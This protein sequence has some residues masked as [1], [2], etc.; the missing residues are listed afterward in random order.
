MSRTES[1]L[2][3]AWRIWIRLLLL[4]FPETFRHEVG[5]DL[6]ADCTA[7]PPSRIA[8]FVRRSASAARELVPAGLGARLD[9]RRARRDGPRG[10]LGGGLA[11]D[12]RYGLRLLIRQPVYSGAV[13]LTLAL[14][15]GLA[16]AVFGIVDATL[17]RPLPFPADRRLLSIGSRW[18]GV[19]HTAV[20]IP[21]YLD[22]RAQA[23]SLESIAAYRHVSASLVGDDGPERLGG[24]AVT[25]SFFDV[26]GVQPALGRVFTDAE[27]GP[28][29]DRVAVLAHHT[30][31]QRFGRD[32]AALGRA[33]R[34]D[35]QPVTIIGVM[36]ASFRLPA[37]DTEIWF[38][39]RVNPSDPGGRGAH[40][41]EVIARM[42]AGVEP[43]A[44]R[45]ELAAIGRQFA[46]DYPQN[47]PEGSG[48]GV[49]V[50]TLRDH[51]VGD[52]SGPLR[53]LFGA[54]LFV[55]L[56]AA[57]NTSGLMLARASE[58][59]AEFAARAALGASRLRLVRQVVVEGA[60]AGAAGGA[61][62][63]LGAE[64][65]LRA[66]EPG[67]PPAVARPSTLALD[68][69]VIAFA[70]GVTGCAAAL[71]GAFAASQAS[72]ASAGDALRSGA[73]TTAGR[74]TR[75]VRAALVVGE[76][77]LAFLLLTGA[78][79]SIRGF[80]RLLD[81]DPGLD[82]SSV[83]TARL[84]LPAARYP[85]IRD[86]VAFFHRLLDSLAASP[87]VTHAGAVSILP[88]S[89][90]DTDA[91]FGVEGYV[92]PV[93]GQ[94]P[95]S[96]ARYVTG[97]YFRALDI[98]LV[99]GRLFTRADG[100]DAPFVAI[101]SD[102]LARKYWPGVD[103]VGRRMKMWSLDDDGPWRTV[104][105][106]VGDVRHFG[107]AEDAP[108][109]LYLPVAQFPQRTLT[110]VVEAAEGLPAGRL[111]EER[112]RALDPAQPV[113][114][115][116]TMDGWVER[117]TAQPRFSLRLLSVFATAALT[118]AA[119]GIY[120]VMAFTVAGRSRELGI[121][122][123]LGADPRKLIWLVMVRGLLLAAAGL[124]L[125]VGGAVLTGRY[126][127]S[128]LYGVQPIEPLVHAAAAAVLGA[129]AL[130]ACALP[131]RGILRLDPTTALRAE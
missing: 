96:Q 41:R 64:I 123:A 51:L 6:V 76:I 43:D 4:A 56:I 75:R 89:G 10:L 99:R 102:A 57:A 120:G 79:L 45:D 83:T 112:V 127:A 117:A 92:P 68:A 15:S 85:Q 23:R 1:L 107:L 115:A 72:R 116:R 34:I 81:V 9:D 87:G 108:P 114:D 48:W 62:G 22:Y 105:G 110:I 7:D 32:P 29:G 36:P 5:A 47:Y 118:L 28:G 109:I 40:N 31:Q 18:T 35:D 16:T 17:V 66:L 65:L 74:A 50:R 125:G 111:I 106:V 25:A 130:L 78:G 38:P 46:R 24:A 101:V 44:A 63:L 37:A 21:E 55:L 131:A 11:A 86:A 13:V 128:L 77:A 14:G 121:R 19:E 73:R 26:L 94:A 122:V 80:T 98:P 97:D 70:L 71:A 82:V 104:V 129:V 53:L 113:Y 33:V 100:P 91:N 126:L 60:I 124:A 39:L 8:Q 49:S 93:P 20:S 52:V 54:V 119:L 90:S 30:W 84:S 67:L 2:A 61:L 69:R 42:R 59:R 3:R 103:P 58:R 12:V 88:L 27:D 95:N